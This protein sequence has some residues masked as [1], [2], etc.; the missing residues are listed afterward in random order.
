MKVLISDY[1]KTFYT[2]EEDIKLNI[3]T[4]NEFMKKNM[5]IIATGRSYLDFE[6]Q[7]K[8][9][10][11][12]YNY[13]IINHGATIVYNDKVIYNELI[14]NNI[15]NKI[16]NIVNKEKIS[17]SFACNELE[18]RLSLSTDKLTKIHVEYEK[19]ENL[20][21]VYKEL[22]KFTDI[23]NIYVM[24]NKKSLE[25]ISQRV[26]KANAINYLIEKNIIY[27]DDIYTIGDNYNDL[28]MLQI[29]NGATMT[30]SINVLSN[31][32]L[33]KYDTVSDYIIEIEKT[34]N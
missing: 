8:L 33:K 3:K 23:I 22:L 19:E 34:T 14:D 24:N 6:K 16:N 27:K 1:D 18:S 28:E 30:N 26:N 5:F 12:K 7:K 32:N 13:L 10:N 20:N 29:Y 21:K 2:N 31:L 11:I 17:N 15:L 4:T 9:Y 25:I